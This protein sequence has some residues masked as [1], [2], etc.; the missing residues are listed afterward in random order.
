MLLLLHSRYNSSYK[1]C[2]LLHTYT[3]IKQRT[4]YYLKCTS[5]EYGAHL[6]I[7]KVIVKRYG[8]MCSV[9]RVQNG[10]Q[11]PQHLGNEI[12]FTWRCIY[13]LFSSREGRTFIEVGR[14][15]F[16]S[17]SIFLVWCAA[18]NKSKWWIWCGRRW[19]MWI[20]CGSISPLKSGK[21]SFFLLETHST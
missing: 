3:I 2:S 5:S 7:W 4:F 16:Y 19:L 18:R 9:C 10:L 11:L 21:N 13:F 15:W 14:S 17:N 6:F 12:F 8:N 20:L 1:T